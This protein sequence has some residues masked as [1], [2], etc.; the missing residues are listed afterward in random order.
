MRPQN[1][2]DIFTCTACQTREVGRDEFEC[3]ACGAYACEHLVLIEGG[4]VICF[5]CYKDQGIKWPD[6]CYTILPPKPDKS[7]EP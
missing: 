7:E 3:G 2:R 4:L 1:H 6:Y 5:C